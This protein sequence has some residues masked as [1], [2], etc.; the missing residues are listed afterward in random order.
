MSAVAV[1]ISRAL[2]RDIEEI[3]GAAAELD[4][5][6]VDPRIHDVGACVR[7]RARIVVR[8]GC[9]AAAGVAGPVGEAV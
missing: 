4:V 5:L 6:R 8:V 1:T 9:L 7:A 2:A 3:R